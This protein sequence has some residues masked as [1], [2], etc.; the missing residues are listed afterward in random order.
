[1]NPKETIRRCSRS[2][3]PKHGSEIKARFGIYRRPNHYEDLCEKCFKPVEIDEN[4]RQ[5]DFEDGSL[6]SIYDYRQNR[7]LDP[8][9]LNPK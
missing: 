3:W 5:L 7:L 6:I 9:T 2:N 8:T 1:M 4:I